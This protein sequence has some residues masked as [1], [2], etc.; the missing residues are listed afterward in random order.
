MTSSSKQLHWTIA[1]MP[2]HI[3]AG[4]L[5]NMNTVLQSFTLRMPVVLLPSSHKICSIATNLHT[6]L[7]AYKMVNPS[8]IEKN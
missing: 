7:Y 1:Y 2:A 8:D 3:P 5:C 4:L 6:C